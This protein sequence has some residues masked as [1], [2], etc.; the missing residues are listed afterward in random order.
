ML[1]FSVFY[2]FSIYNSLVI[3]LSVVVF[4]CITQIVTAQ[5]IKLS[6]QSI[7]PM[8][9]PATKLE[10]YQYW[11]TW[12]SILGVLAYSE[13]YIFEQLTEYRTFPY[14]NVTGLVHFGVIGRLVGFVWAKFHSD[15]LSVRK[16]E[17]EVDAIK[18]P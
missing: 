1:I 10:S 13:V 9:Y 6:I 2:S 4:T 3:S 11:T 5:E 18:L 8:E 15:V 16:I 7:W 12:F 14:I 17:R